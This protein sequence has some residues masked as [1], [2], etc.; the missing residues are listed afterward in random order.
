M[1]YGGRGS[2]S[3]LPVST[4]L[5]Q[6]TEQGIFNTVEMAQHQWDQPAVKSWMDV[7]KRSV[8]TS[9]SSSTAQEYSISWLQY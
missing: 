3:S 6:G 8:G 7:L 9:S 2:S 5:A 4:L 1:R